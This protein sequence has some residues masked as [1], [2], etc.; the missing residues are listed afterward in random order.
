[1]EAILLGQKTKELLKAQFVSIL[2]SY[3]KSR[4]AFT[5][6]TSGWEKEELIAVTKEQV[7]IL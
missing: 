7:R 1:M 4:E 3:I 6:I 2:D 5:M